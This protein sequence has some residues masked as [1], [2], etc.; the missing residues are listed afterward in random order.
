MYNDNQRF[1]IQFVF[2]EKKQKLV[3][4]QDINNLE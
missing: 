4:C 1:D 2:G 3:S